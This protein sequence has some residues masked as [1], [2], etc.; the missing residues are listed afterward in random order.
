MEA[1][2]RALGIPDP[3]IQLA[4]RQAREAILRLHAYKPQNDGPLPR[5][6]QSKIPAY[7]SAGLL[8]PVHVGN[9]GRLHVLLTVRAQGLNSH[10]GDTAFPGGRFELYDKDIE[11][12]A[13]REA[14]EETGLPI[15]PRIVLKLCEMETF[16]SANEL[17][18][19]PIVAFITDMTL[20][21]RANTNEVSA[22]FTIPFES[23]LFETLPPAFYNNMDITPQ[24]ERYSTPLPGS[25]ETPESAG[26]TGDATWHTA[27][28]ISWIGDVRMRRH[29]F[30]E[31]N[32]PIRGLTSD[33]LLRAAI[34][35][36]GREP[37]YAA[38]VKDQPSQAALLRLAF[39]SP[40][41]VRE[42]NVR[43]RIRPWKAKV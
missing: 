32:N 42:R 31:A 26:S 6:L 4:D 40:H 10:G 1:A 25:T 12:T 24:S 7:R 14:Y 8:V 9:D 43:P 41:A 17:A 28:D 33:V 36:Y 3:V 21:L 23:V 38:N 29:T 39:A 11:Y 37:T 34:V 5:A 30:W 27:Y 35:A 2:L 13:R 15:N 19:T 18:V 20:P 16:L 22:M